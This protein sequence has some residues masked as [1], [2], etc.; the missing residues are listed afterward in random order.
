MAILSSPA[1]SA[2]NNL[3]PANGLLTAKSSDS[4]AIS[5]S[6][7][8]GKEQSSL[9]L[10]GSFD[11]Q[12]NINALTHG[13]YNLPDGS[14]VSLS[15]PTGAAHIPLEA[16][17]GELRV[18]RLLASL[19]A[20]D[21]WI[22][23]GDQADQ[24]NAGAG[25]DYI[26]ANAGPD[27]VQGSAGNDF[28]AGGSGIDTAVFT[29]PRAHYSISNASNGFGITNQTG[30]E[31]TDTLNAVERLQFSD[32]QMALDLDGH[33]GQVARILG[34]VSAPKTLATTSTWASGFY[35]WIAG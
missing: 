29:G 4:I 5:F 7:V 18:D 19:L 25:D 26:D 27:R 10:Y 1:A 28:I 20:G 14:A 3:T 16:S 9:K 17:A 22:T 23:L 8:G 11:A 35:C 15:F 12:G 13:V 24:V 2:F 30:S 6:T 21:D 33:A 34:A 32:A 31:G